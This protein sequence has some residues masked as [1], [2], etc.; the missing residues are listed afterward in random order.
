MLVIRACF[1]SDHSQQSLPRLEFSGNCNL[2]ANGGYGSH[3]SMNGPRSEVHC[4]QEVT[5]LDGIPMTGQTAN[6]FVNSSESPKA[7]SRLAF[8]N[9]MESSVK[10]AQSKFVNNNL[11]GAEMEN[12][13][14][15]EVDDVD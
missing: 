1:N 5:G 11:G 14:E 6:G 10:E 8:V 9:S 3:H 2:M 13:F 4:G 12:H 7:D 15:D